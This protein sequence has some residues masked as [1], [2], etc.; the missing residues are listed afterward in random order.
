MVDKIFQLKPPGVGKRIKQLRKR[1]PMSQK[2][3]ALAAQSTQASVLRAEK[4]A[5]C[6]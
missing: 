3:L 6:N 5:V 2:E 1:L 4:G